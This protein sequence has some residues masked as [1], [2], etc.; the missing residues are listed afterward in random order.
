MLHF[1]RLSKYGWEYIQVIYFRNSK[2]T[3][4]SS[5][6]SAFIDIQ[7]AHK[8]IAN[9]MAQQVALYH[10]SMKNW[11]K[12]SPSQVFFFKSKENKEN[13]IFFGKVAWSWLRTCTVSP[14]KMSPCQNQATAQND[15]NDITW[16]HPFLTIH[17]FFHECIADSRESKMCCADV[18]GFPVLVVIFVDKS[19]D[20]I[21]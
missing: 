1:K 16:S 5:L 8:A 15:G 4:W 21:M 17:D 6:R 3:N 11:L 9:R 10:I 13:I 20:R 12:S 14:V 2:K 18:R 7:H 19:C